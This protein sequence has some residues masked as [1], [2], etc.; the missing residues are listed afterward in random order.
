MDNCIYDKPIEK[1]KKLDLLKNKNTKNLL[2]NKGKNNNSKNN[3]Y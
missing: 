1:N 2:D 3:D